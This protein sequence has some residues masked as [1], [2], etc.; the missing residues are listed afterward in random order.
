ME[1][2]NLHL[3]VHNTRIGNIHRAQN[4]DDYHYYSVAVTAVQC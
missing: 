2:L 1:L 4:L 3:S